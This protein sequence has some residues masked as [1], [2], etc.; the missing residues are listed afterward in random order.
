MVLKQLNDDF[1][2]S[3]VVL[4]GDDTHD[5]CCVFSI[6]V[7]TVL[8]SQHKTSVRLLHLRTTFGDNI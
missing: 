5:V 1:D 6:R 4:D 2:V 3:V 8:V 7:L